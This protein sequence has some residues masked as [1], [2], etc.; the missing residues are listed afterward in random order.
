MTKLNIHHI[1]RIEGHGNVAIDVKDNEV[2]D[3]FMEIIEPTRV[4]EAMMR[5]RR[6]DEVSHISS[7]ICGI[8]SPNHFVTNLI[9]VEDALGIKVSE[10]TKKLRQLL[11]HGSY[12]QNHASALYIFAAPDFVGLPSFVPLAE[13]AP[14][15]VRRALRL[16]KLGNDL[17][18]LIGGRPVHPITPT[19]GGFTDDVSAEALRHL[20][21]QLFEAV[22]DAAATVELF[23]EIVPQHFDTQGELVALHEI[24]LY[25]TVSGQ[26]TALDAGWSKPVSEY[27]NII[28]EKVV[29]HS[30]SK[31][32][33]IDGKTFMTGPLARVNVSWDQLLPSARVVASKIGLRPVNRNIFSAHACRAIELV[34]AAE[35]CATLADE[36]SLES[37]S[38]AP[39]PFKVKAGT[40]YGA[41]EAPRG[42]LYHSVTI[43]SDGMVTAADV[44]TPTA[45]NLANLAL[46]LQRFS[47]TVVEKGEDEFKKS[48]EM[49]VRCYDPCMSCAVH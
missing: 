30:N 43:D 34:D 29:E 41:S 27:P 2:K 22:A 25:A 12:L 15:I 44:V 33:F 39:K 42:T 36:L 18:T 28:K 7:R 48:V 14:E 1:A 13:S 49:L 47:P 9:A 3:I 6:F 45:Q 35:R 8:C 10:R 16:K 4:F 32:S 21:E 23:G 26:I 37:G 40:G 38:V 31:H 19:V 11:V 24:D 17:C 20:S 5:G 46:D